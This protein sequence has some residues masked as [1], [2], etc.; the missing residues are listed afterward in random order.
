[1][2]SSDDNDPPSLE[3]NSEK[4]F[5]GGLRADTTDEI[6]NHH[7]SKYGE[8]RDALVV[9]DRVTRKSRCFG[10]VTFQHSAMANSAFDQEHIILGRK[11]DVKRAIPR[12]KHNNGDLDEQNNGAT[13]VEVINKQNSNA[14]EFIPKKIFVGGLPS[15]LTEQE[16]KDYFQGFGTVA[17]VLLIFDKT[18]GESRKF[19]FVTFDA[20]DS[21]DNVMR[22]KFH[23][24][25]QKL[26][27]V[28]RAVPRDNY[29]DLKPH[30]NQ[31]ISSKINNSGELYYRIHHP[32]MGYCYWWPLAHDILPWD[33]ERP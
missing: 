29:Q 9:T 18:T 26:V 21:V 5:V 22:N 6:L 17:N 2:F 24:L 28:K 8:V 23:K 27:E 16:F 1:M 19:G 4:L 33:Y 20:E 30:Q 10:F 7:F 12:R 25:K 14:T 31:S 11:V 32:I 3:S 15:N 13:T